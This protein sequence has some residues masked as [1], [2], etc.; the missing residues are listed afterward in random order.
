MPEYV[1]FC[2]SVPDDVI[3]KPLTL[4]NAKVINDLWPHG[5]TERSYLEIIDMIKMRE[6]IGIYNKVL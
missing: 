4:E 5:Q 1:I 2:F 6:H 3:L